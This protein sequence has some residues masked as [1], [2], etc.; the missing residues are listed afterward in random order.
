MTLALEVADKMCSV[1][2]FWVVGFSLGAGALVLSAIHPV[3]RVVVGLVA[4]LLIWADV[5]VTM[6]DFRR[7]AIIR[8]LG[9]SYYVHQFAAMS[10]PLVACLFSG[11]IIRGV[12]RLNWLPANRPMQTDG[13]SGRR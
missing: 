6:D 10:L 4:C 2:H 9:V 3:I 8:E 13:P 7:P 5:T 12:R 11:V 1:G